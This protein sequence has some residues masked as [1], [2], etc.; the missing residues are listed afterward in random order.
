MQSINQRERHLGDRPGRERLIFLLPGRQKIRVKNDVR[1]E[2]LPGA[3][4]HLGQTIRP[5]PVAGS[6]GEVWIGQR[7]H[8][9]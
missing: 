6:P 1:I 3:V 5:I 8:V 2:N 4:V 9:H 7:R